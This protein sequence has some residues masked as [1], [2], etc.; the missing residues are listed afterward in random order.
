MGEAWRLDGAARRRQL[1]GVLF[2]KLYVR[3]GAITKYVAKREHREEVVALIA[4]AVGA[5]L[6]YDHPSTGRGS[7]LSRPRARQLLTETGREGSY[8]ACA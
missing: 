1:L 2:E 6:Q 3:D 8:S 5:G 7:N 4:L